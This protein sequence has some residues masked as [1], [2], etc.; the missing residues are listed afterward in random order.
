MQ[1]AFSVI[2]LAAG[3]SSRMGQ[4][5]A[6]LVW[7]G[8]A[9]WQKQ[10][11]LARALGSDD[12]L[13]S[14]PMLGQ[15]DHKPGF[16]P[17]SGLHTLLPQCLHEKVLVLP[18]DMPLLSPILLQPL[19]Q[20]EGSAYFEDCALPC[21][22]MHNPSVH[23]YIASQLHDRGQRSVRALLEHCQAQALLCPVPEFLVNANTPEQWQA[24]TTNPLIKEAI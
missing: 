5:K 14:H 16:G 21:V 13:I 24:L 4:D 17:L 11:E 2:I 9:M 22:L 6:Q 18:I 10:L 20:A 15:A 12:I 1:E 7:Q 19:L 23:A 3:Q 8:Q